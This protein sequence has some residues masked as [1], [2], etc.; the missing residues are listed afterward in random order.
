MPRVFPVDV[1]KCAV[2]GS[3]S[4]WGPAIT[5]GETIVRILEHPG[6]ESRAPSPAPA[7]APP[8]HELG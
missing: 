4:R 5:R 1:L 7:R 8:Q 2:C 3:R 6:L